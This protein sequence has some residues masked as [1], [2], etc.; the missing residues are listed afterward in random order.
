MTSVT[1]SGA[2]FAAASDTAAPVSEM[3]RKVQSKLLPLNDSLAGH[4]TLVRGD[5][6]RSGIPSCQFESDVIAHAYR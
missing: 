4:C 2:L 3:F 6:R 1:I 5:P